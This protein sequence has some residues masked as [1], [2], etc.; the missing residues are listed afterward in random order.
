MNNQLLV[1]L[2]SVVILNQVI[3][4]LIIYTITLENPH[5]G[6]D[7]RKYYNYYYNYYYYYYTFLMVS[8]VINI[9]KDYYYYYYYYYT[10]F[11]KILFESDWLSTTLIS[12]FIKIKPTQIKSNIYVSI[13][14]NRISRLINVRKDKINDQYNLIRVVELVQRSNQIDQR[15][16]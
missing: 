12:A 4:H 3:L 8:F 6:R 5:K 9:I 15:I 2:L 1:Q 13:T 16:D 10:N 7:N 11:N 14:E